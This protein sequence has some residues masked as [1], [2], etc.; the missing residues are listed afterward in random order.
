MA[1][2]QRDVAAA[3][4]WFRK[5]L[6]IDDDAKWWDWLSLYAWLWRYK[7]LSVFSK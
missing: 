4:K 6:E 7:F 5:A 3:E 2:K 1:G